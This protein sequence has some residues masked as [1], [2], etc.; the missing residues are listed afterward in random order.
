M[1]F[2]FIPPKGSDRL[3]LKYDIIKGESMVPHPRRVEYLAAQL[4]MWYCLD[5]VLLQD[6]KHILGRV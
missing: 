4:E 2:H 3:L 5:E 6:I 1:C